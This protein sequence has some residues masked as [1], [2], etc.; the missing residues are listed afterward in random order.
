MQVLHDLV[1]MNPPPV[2]VHHD[3]AAIS[4]EPLQSVF[5]PDRREGWVW[6]AGHDIPKNKSKVESVG[7]TDGV[8]V[9]LSVGR[10]KQLC[11]MTVLGFEKTNRTENFLFLLFCRKE[12]QMRVDLPMGADFKERDLKESPYLP[13][14]FRYPFSGHEEGG[15]D[16]LLDQIVDQGLIET[17]SVTHWAE[18]K[19]QCDTGTRGRARFNHLSLC[20]GEERRDEQRRKG[21]AQY[22]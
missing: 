20:E 18:V 5:D 3:D 13:I 9:E 2:G 1:R 12:R 8:V 21:K 22:P 17:C 11:I 19:R 14:V 6:I 4:D 15:R 10:A 16:L 7:H